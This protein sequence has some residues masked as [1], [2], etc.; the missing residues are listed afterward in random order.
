[1]TALV[2]TGTGTEVGKTIVTAAIAALAVADGRSVTVV[3]PAQTGV[4]PGEEAD[5]DVVR[6]LSGVRDAHELVRYDDPLAPATAAR[7]QGRAAIPVGDLVEETRSWQDC[8]LLLVEGAGGLLVELDD[9]GATI[10][11]VAGLL[12]ADVLV[13]AASGLG[14]LNATALTCEAA[15]HRG[16]RCR[17]VVIGSWPADPALA[18]CCNLVDLPRYA[19]APLLGA[20]PANARRLSAPAFLAVARAGLAAELGGTWHPEA[21]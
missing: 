12:G 19:Q 2:V 10:A 6:R 8:D 5:I 18:E 20:M 16:L 9:D 14:T 1:M 11:D 21:L 4:M 15:R 17:G 3:K 7:R 13:V